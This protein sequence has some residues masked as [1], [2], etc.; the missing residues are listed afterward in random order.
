MPNTDQTAQATSASSNNQAPVADEFDLG[1]LAPDNSET[2][3]EESIAPDSE[4]TST[5]ETSTVE[6][7]DNSLDFNMD[8]PDSYSE[9]KPEETPATP[10]AEETNTQETEN[11]VV[12]DIIL[13]GEASTET[14]DTITN[15]PVPTTEIQPQIESST[16]ENLTVDTPNTWEMVNQQ[17][18]PVQSGGMFSST[19]PSDET[20][21]PDIQE[22]NE[23]TENIDN[24]VDPSA[25]LFS[26]APADTNLNNQASP[27]I[28]F[29]SPSSFWSEPKEGESLSDALKFQEEVELTEE[30]TNPLAENTATENEKNNETPIEETP[31]TI[32]PLLEEPTTEE[33]PTT[34][35]MNTITEEQTNPNLLLEEPSTQEVNIPEP[36]QDNI[37]ENT[38]AAPLNLDAMITQDTPTAENATPQETVPSQETIPSQ[39][40]TQE[41]DPFMAMKQTLEGKNTIEFQNT[42]TWE[43]PTL[44]LNTIP[45]QDAQNPI[46]ASPLSKLNISLGG[47]SSK[48]YLVPVLSVLWIVVAWVLVFIRYPDLFSGIGG[49]STPTTPQVQVTPT[50]PEKEHGSYETGDINIPTTGD[51]TSINTWSIEEEPIEEI[52]PTMS[53][54]PVDENLIKE[55]NPEIQ[56]ID[57]STNDSTETTT[58]IEPDPIQSE[59]IQSEPIPTNPNEDPNAPVDPLASIEGLVG[60]LNNTDLIKQEV[61]QY[62][63]KGTELKDQG[64]A[65]GKRR[66]YAYGAKIEKQ[67]T[68]L[69]VRL[70]KGENIDIST[71]TE[72]KATFDDYI[73]KA[74]AE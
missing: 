7:S 15:E 23:N 65:S 52:E 10:I 29:D 2:Q 28:S 36:T 54:V 62:Q 70:E 60:N 14:S 13:P 30:T 41:I 31:S 67:A 26:E 44:D 27:D 34:L 59:P 58:P 32:N 46:K 56:V 64:A 8:L 47:A 51:D 49:S 4:K 37:Q 73:Q 6:S 16:E 55:E 25:V 35:D 69:I 66:A 11:N 68:D 17:E 72:L 40:N 33:T 53:V 19:Q 5:E 61:M 42:G 3:T 12:A 39:E 48:K 57:L 50:D 71:W 20:F 24:T 1:M 9:N 21:I 45:S 22:N 18:A 63:I 74:N 38:A 43:K